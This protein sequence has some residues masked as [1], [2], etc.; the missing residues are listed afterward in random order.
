MGQII[1]IGSKGSWIQ[2]VL[3]CQSHSAGD[4]YFAENLYYDIVHFP[5]Y[6]SLRLDVSL[7][8]YFFYFVFWV[9]LALQSS[10]WVFGQHFLL[11]LNS[12]LLKA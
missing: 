2:F 10:W 9:F 6:F 4:L 11:G 12:L 5:L 1:F 8:F 3:I 7:G